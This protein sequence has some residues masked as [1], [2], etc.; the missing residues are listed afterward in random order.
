MNPR[1]GSCRLRL[2]A[3]RFTALGVLGLV[4]SLRTTSA[5]PTIAEDASQARGGSGPQVMATLRNLVIGVLCRA[6][7]VNVAAALHRHARNP[8]LQLSR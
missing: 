3:R 8:H 6:G 2:P 4:V 5:I 1:A 7:P